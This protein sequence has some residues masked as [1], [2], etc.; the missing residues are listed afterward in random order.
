MSS[1]KAI[2]AAVVATLA[3]AVPAKAG[4]PVESKVTMKQSQANEAKFKGRVSSMASDCVVGRK[5]V[6]FRK[7][8]GKDQKLEKTFATESGKWRVKVPMQSGNK[9]Y[10]LVDFVVTPLDTQCQA[11]KSPTVTA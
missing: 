2:A 5:V 6:V 4:G 9:L 3:F 8:Q 7:E 10:A 11:D 1:S